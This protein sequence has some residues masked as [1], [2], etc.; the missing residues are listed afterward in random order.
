MRLIYKAEPG[1]HLKL[2][3]D[4]RALVAHPDH[5]LMI[6]DQKGS[7][8]LLTADNCPEIWPIW[9]SV[10]QQILRPN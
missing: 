3:S 9:Q 7:K 2:L 10:L 5:P 6:V 8:E 4:G 1:E